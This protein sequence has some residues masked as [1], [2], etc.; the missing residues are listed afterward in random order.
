[1][2]RYSESREEREAAEEREKER[3]RA[4]KDGKKWERF[5]E[6]WAELENGGAAGGGGGGPLKYD[7]IPW[8]PKMSQLLHHAAGLGAGVGLYKL[9]PVDP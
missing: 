9:N 8:P 3:E 1:V 4:K 6:R 5:E 7:D 2:Y